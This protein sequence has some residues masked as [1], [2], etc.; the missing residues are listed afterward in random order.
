LLGDDAAAVTNENPM[1][2]LVW[3][4]QTIL[5]DGEGAIDGNTNNET[6]RYTNNT[7]YD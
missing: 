1:F 5:L 3:T 4:T 6:K 2:H 7:K